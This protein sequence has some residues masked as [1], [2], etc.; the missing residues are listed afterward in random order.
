M[1]AV[2]IIERTDTRGEFQPFGSIYFTR[3]IAAGYIATFP[4]NKTKYRIMQY[5][6]NVGGV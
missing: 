4:L 6:R 2:F 3:E 5:V 1:K